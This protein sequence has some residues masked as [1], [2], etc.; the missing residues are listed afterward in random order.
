MVD[1]VGVV[2]GRLTVISLFK[3]GAKG[4]SAIWECRCICGN[5]KKVSGSNLRSKN[6]VSCGCYHK[7]I[8]TVHGKMIKYPLEY[9]TWSNIKQRCYNIKHEKYKY[10]GGRGIK[11]C[12]RWLNSFENFFTDMGPKPTE[13]H[14]IDRFP[15]KDGN[16]GPDNCRWATMKEQNNNLNKNILVT[17]QFQTNSISEWSRLLKMYPT[18]L[19][20]RLKKYSL[21]EI[22][23]KYKPDFKLQ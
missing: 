21:R 5:V 2:F 10:Y 23:E 9:R 7:E 6:T 16:Y 11:V 12:D 18:T 22:I 3:K 14:T 19:N 1:I 17:Y 13:K 20:N 4:Y 8:S 15:N